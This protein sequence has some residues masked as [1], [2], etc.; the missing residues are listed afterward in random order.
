MF[1]LREAYTPPIFVNARRLPKRGA[2]TRVG[3]TDS[4]YTDSNGKSWTFTDR[5]DEVAAGQ[6]FVGST[7]AYPDS[8][9]KFYEPTEAALTATVESL[10][11]SQAGGSSE[12]YSSSGLSSSAVDEWSVS[13]DA[14]EGP[15]VS[16]SDLVETMAKEGVSEEAAFETMVK[17]KA[18]TAPPPKAPPT[19]SGGAALKA[20]Q[21]SLMTLGYDLG[22]AY[23]ADGKIGPYTR[24][25]ITKFKKDHGIT[26]AD[27]TINEPFRKALADAVTEK[28]TGVP[29]PG[30]SAAG[31][32]S[33]VWYVLGAVAA[34]AAG[35]YFFMK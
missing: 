30:A 20:I 19:A 12:S 1:Q 29:A 10:A 6:R 18:A 9:Y 15:V 7:D 27:A 5:G 26:P 28:K 8:T 24:G 31:S 3:A 2:A 17:K 32:G 13:V 35:V 11:K 22:S 25:A 34:V 21:T 33:S 16:E 14:A 4:S 23:G